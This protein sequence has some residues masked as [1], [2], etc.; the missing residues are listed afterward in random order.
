MTQQSTDPGKTSMTR[1]QELLDRFYWCIGTLTIP[2]LIVV[3]SV[4]AIAFWD[5]VY[6][7]EP[8]QQKI[9]ASCPM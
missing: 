4:I 3:L 9:S 8:Q 2:A 1:V 5:D 7:S 6:S